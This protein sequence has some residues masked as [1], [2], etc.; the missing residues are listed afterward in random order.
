MAMLYAVVWIV[1][2]EPC[3]VDCGVGCG[4]GCH[5]ALGCKIT[6]RWRPVQGLLSE[7]SDGFSKV[8]LRA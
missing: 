1:W 5:Q 7:R 2:R 6:P 4:E 3:G 8:Q